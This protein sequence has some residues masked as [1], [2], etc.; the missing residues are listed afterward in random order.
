MWIR[1][2]LAQCGFNQYSHKVDLISNHSMRILTLST[3]IATP[4]KSTH[5]DT[6]ISR[7]L[8]VQI[9]IEILV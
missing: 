7:Y 3:E 5:G 8:A 6:Q 9:Q 4:P 1:L 2:V